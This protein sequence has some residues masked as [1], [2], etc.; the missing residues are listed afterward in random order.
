MTRET[1]AQLRQLLTFERQRRRLSERK[2]AAALAELARIRESQMDDLI[3][4]GRRE[5]IATQRAEQAGTAF[6]E[7]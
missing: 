7:T 3:A 5:K 4:S 6:H 1:N 2:C